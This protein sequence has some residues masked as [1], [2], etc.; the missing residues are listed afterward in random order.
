[1]EPGTWSCELW[2]KLQ[3]CV[4]WVSF[5]W[6]FIFDSFIVWKHFI[7]KLTNL[8]ETKYS[9]WW[10]ARTWNW[11]VQTV[12]DKIENQVDAYEEQWGPTDRRDFDG[13][14]IVTAEIRN[15]I[16]SAKGSLR[17]HGGLLTISR[18][19][20]FLS[21]SNNN[22]SS[23]HSSTPD[24]SR[25]V[26]NTPGSNHKMSLT[27][28]YDS[29]LEE[30]EDDGVLVIKKGKAKDKRKN[31]KT[32]TTVQQIFGSNNVQMRRKSEDLLESRTSASSNNVSSMIAIQKQ[33]Q[34]VRQSSDQGYRLI[35]RVKKPSGFMDGFMNRSNGQSSNAIETKRFNAPTSKST[36]ALDTE[37]I[38]EPELCPTRWGNVRGSNSFSADLN[39][40]SLSTYSIPRVSLSQHKVQ[41]ADATEGSNVARKSLPENRLSSTFIM[42]HD[43]DDSA[44]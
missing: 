38:N 8:N 44:A 24:L 35:P 34:H 1:M 33:Q 39:I 15:R 10:N 20:T 41:L 37:I 17:I 40:A 2:W 21:L 27:S 26:P 16:N 43:T 23:I 4:R 31:G 30:N 32:R 13:D 25:S 5:L 12:L 29:V 18:S 19:R 6:M 11:I 42:R 36:V 28:S 14:F 9:L 22:R 3:A 7:T